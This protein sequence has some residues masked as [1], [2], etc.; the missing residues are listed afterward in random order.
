MK[1]YLNSIEETLKDTGSSLQGLTQAEAERRLSQN[2]KNKLAE[3]KKE[4][5]AHMFL[6]QLA[7]PMII[8]LI[9]AAAVSAVISVTQGESFADVIIIGAVVLLNAVLGVYQE[10]KAEKAIEALQQMT[11]ATSKVIRDGVLRV[12]KSEDLVKGDIVVLEAGDSVPADARVIECASLKTEESAL[13]GESLPVNK[14]D[15]PIAAHGDGN[16]PLGDRSNMVYMGSTAVYGRGRAVITL[17]KNKKHD[18]EIVIDRL[19]VR[20]DA[21]SRL[22]DSV[23]TAL[24]LGDNL[25]IVSVVGGED[26]LFSQLYACPVCGI[27]V[28]EL[29]PRMFSFNNPYGACPCCSGLGFMTTVDPAAVI[30]DDSKTLNEGAIRVSGWDSAESGGAMA[31]MYLEALSRHYGFS[32]DEPVKNLSKAHIDLIL[33]G[34]KGEKIKCEYER[35]GRRGSFSSPFEGIVTNLERRYRETS[36]DLSKE[37]LEEYMLPQGLYRIHRRKPR[38][39]S[40]DPRHV[41]R[42]F[43]QKVHPGG[44]RL[45]PAQRL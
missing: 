2:G 34:T 8:I 11:A 18:I 19:I 7:D 17:D 38:D 5:L 44:I 28:E 25:V 21:L 27:S 4:S 22:T 33:Y 26:M 24:R 39:H 32:L 9:V 14:T 35:D 29:T 41:Q 36:S 31:R 10:S 1:Y 16:V 23:E 45:P 3:G 6:R 37:S 43:R 40:P 42:R 20:P 30:P 12:V 15:K 13:T